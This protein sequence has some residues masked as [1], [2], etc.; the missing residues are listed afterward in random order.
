ME[1]HDFSFNTLERKVSGHGVVHSDF[2]SLFSC[3]G[4]IIEGL[5]DSNVH[6]TALL[7]KNPST[8]T[9]GNGARHAEI[10]RGIEGFI[11]LDGRDWQSY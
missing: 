8:I 10:Y 6:K 5:D 3:W 9:N 7:T 4:C 1:L 2:V 11:R